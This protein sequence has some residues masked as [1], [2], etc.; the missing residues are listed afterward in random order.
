MDTFFAMDTQRAAIQTL[1]SL[2]ILATSKNIETIKGRYDFL[3]TII[4]TLKS[5]KN[6]SQY[7]TIIQSALGQFKTIYP[8]SVLQ[9]YQLTV[10]SNPDTFDSKNFYCTSLVNAINRYYEKQSEEI[11]ALKKE[12]AKTKRVAKVIETIRSA[13]NELKLKCSSV[14]SCSTAIDELEKLI[15]T[16]NKII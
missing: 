5:A 16:S 1:E 13:Q 2:Y 6:D 11:N 8:A 10:L 4:P 9:D 3:L 12:A 14:A 7:L 15:L